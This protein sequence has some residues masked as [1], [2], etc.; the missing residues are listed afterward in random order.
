MLTYGVVCPSEIERAGRSRFV[1]ELGDQ[2]ARSIVSFDLQHATHRVEPFASLLRIGVLCQVDHGAPIIPPQHPN[3]LRGTDPIHRLV[4]SK[5]SEPRR[6]APRVRGTEDEARHG[7]MEWA[8]GARDA[9][10]LRGRKMCA[11]RK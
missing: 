4:A 6:Q 2:L 7:V 9:G 1:D 5:T 11:D 8:A 10:G 3:L